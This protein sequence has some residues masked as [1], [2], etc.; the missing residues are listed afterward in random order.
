MQ[1]HDLK[2]S[3]KEYGKEIETTH[4]PPS[5]V[6]NSDSTRKDQDKQSIMFIL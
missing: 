5:S 1:I 4:N 3:E 2:N 6:S